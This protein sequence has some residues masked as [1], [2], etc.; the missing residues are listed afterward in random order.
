MSLADAVPVPPP[1]EKKPR[2]RAAAV[3]GVVGVGSVI[4]VGAWALQV[5]AAQ[6]PQ[7]AEALPSNTLAYV[8]VD[9][10]PPGGQK[11]AAFDA[12]RKFPALKEELDLDGRDDLRRSIVDEATTGSG[13]DVDFDDVEDWAGERAALAV[14]P[15]DEPEVVAVVQIG[16]SGKA[17]AGLK[18]I[19]GSCD[20]FGFAVSDGWAVLASSNEVAQKVETA[21]AR[22]TLADDEDFNELVGAAGEAG[23]VT[24]FA[25]PEAGPALLEASDEDS[26]IAFYLVASPL[27]YADPVSDLINYV[28]LMTFDDSW[29]TADSDDGADEGSD[30]GF[31]EG[32]PEPTPEE[33][34][35]FERMEKYDELT[36]AEQKKLDDEMEAFLSSRVPEPSPEEKALNERME[37]YDELSPADQKKL[38]DE[39]EAFFEEKYGAGI[40]FGGPELPDDVRKALRDFSGLGGVLRFDDGSLELEAVGDP[41]LGGYEGRYDGTD[42]QRVISRLPANTAVAFGGGFADDWAEDT[43]TGSGGYFGMGG[44]EADLLADFKKATGLIPKDLEALGG[45]TIVFAGRDDF[46]KAIDSG[47][48]ETFP[49]A[50]RVTGDPAA[51]EAALAK[52]RATLE[53][54]A[55]TFLTSLRTDDGVVIGPNAA[56]L[57]EL[58][59]PKETLGDSDRFTNVVPDADKA[60]TITFAD[61]DAGNWLEAIAGSDGTELKSLDTAG[62]TVTQDGDQHRF[63]MRVSLD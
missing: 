43:V 30:E 12:L 53:I 18:K 14:V 48:T 60:L 9:L 28:S 21:A 26:F 62:L 10:D 17:E 15:L 25:A 52:L 37:H 40:N 31:P 42:A 1:A 36:P 61:F 63:R 49:I 46:G 29:A 34:A 7:P 39:M 38:D 22:A 41:L 27:G 6:G 8:A 56:Y 16:D 54:D 35:L 55:D 33:E 47:K 4:G 51:I 57:E 3:A 59:D 24:L 44:T 2:R 23:V 20:E 45:D 13:C 50:A 58:V 5:W 19:A 11:V 32:F